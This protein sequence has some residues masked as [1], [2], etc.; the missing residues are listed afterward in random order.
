[1]GYQNREV[2]VKLLVTNYSKMAAVDKRINEFLKEFYPN[3]DYFKGKA[4]DMYWKAQNDVP[5]DF[6]RL[7]RKP[8]QKGGYMTIK[9]QDKEVVTDRIEI[10]VDIP[11]L[12]QA[13]RLFTAERGHCAGDVV[14]TYH[15]YVLEDEHTTISVYKIVNDPRVFLEVEAKT[16]KRVQ[17]ITKA[18]LDQTDLEM[19]WVNNSVFDI[20]VA[21]M[22]INPRP[23]S[24]FLEG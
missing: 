12:T 24:D 11:D 7:R 19:Q 15:V 22:P 18:I 21:Q 14:K 6:V 13:V 17:E 3:A 23:I 1:M 5:G 10:D 16:N 2:E 9:C 20:F 4:G 8:G